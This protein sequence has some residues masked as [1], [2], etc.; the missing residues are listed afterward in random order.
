MIRL[1]NVFI[2]YIK[3]FYSLFNINLDIKNNTLLLGDKMS[4]N[5]IILRL[6]ADIDKNFDGNI[7]ID[8]KDIKN[9]KNYEFDLAYVAKNPYLFK[10]NMEKN[11]AYPLK[12]RRKIL[13]INKNDIKNKVNS[14]ILH[15]KLENFP[16]KIKQMNLSQKKIICLAR[17]IIRSPKYILI[18]NFFEDLDENYINLAIKMIDESNAIII[19][20]DLDKNEHLYPNFNQIKFNSGSVVQ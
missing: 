6:I 11:L 19:A 4:G 20:S 13:K 3:N 10:S 5:W 7:Y 9:I 18:E 14:L 8:D 16:K 17:A 12:I 2:K 15:Y 1:Q